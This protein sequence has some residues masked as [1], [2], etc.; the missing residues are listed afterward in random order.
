MVGPE[1]SVVPALSMAVYK[2]VVVN[3]CAWTFSVP[4]NT[5]MS[6]AQINYHVEKKQNMGV[7]FCPQYMFARTALVNEQPTKQTKKGFT[8]V[9]R[10]G[11]TES[12]VLKNP[13]AI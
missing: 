8:P 10:S 2:I 5:V 13:E 4:I 3:N 9:S 12:S 1:S 11:S 6:S 7:K